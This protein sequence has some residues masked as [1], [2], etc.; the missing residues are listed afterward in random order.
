MKVILQITNILLLA[1]ILRLKYSESYTLSLLF[2]VFVILN[3]ILSLLNKTKVVSG[4][5]PHFLMIIV[6][7]S[8]TIIDYYLWNIYDDVDLLI[9]KVGII[10]YATSLNISFIYFIAFSLRRTNQ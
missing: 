5:H 10:T 8:V 2:L 7:F 9:T 3:F 1:C 6:L 4:K